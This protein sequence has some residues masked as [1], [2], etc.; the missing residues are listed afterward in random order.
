MTQN[1]LNIYYV[2]SVTITKTDVFCKAVAL[3]ISGG[4]REVTCSFSKM[5]EKSF[6][7]SSLLIQLLFKYFSRILPRFK[8]ILFWLH[9]RFPREGFFRKSLFLPLHDSWTSYYTTTDEM[10]TRAII[11]GFQ[12]FKEFKVARIFNKNLGHD[13][14]RIKYSPWGFDP[15]LAPEIY[16]S[17]YFPWNILSG[18]DNIFETKA[19]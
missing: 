18:Y 6:R 10:R 15:N 2:V 3:T 11:V 16:V 12:I 4:S 14:Y 19:W 8:V 1:G 17:F 9:F 5:L 13:N 7:S